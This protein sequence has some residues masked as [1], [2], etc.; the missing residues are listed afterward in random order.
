MQKF[1]FL[2]AAQ[3]FLGKYKVKKVSFKIYSEQGCS[4]Q[5]SSGGAHIKECIKDS[6][7]RFS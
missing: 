5:I 2:R 1:S 4:A 6:S 3:L 7:C